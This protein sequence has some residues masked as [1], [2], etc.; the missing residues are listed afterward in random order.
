[1]AGSSRPID[2]RGR[3][4]F[5]ASGAA[6]IR[7]RRDK[8]PTTAASRLSTNVK[9]LGRVRELQERGA[10][11]AEVTVESLINEADAIMKLA[12]ERSQLSAA[13]SALREK[14]ILSGKRV[15][16][17]ERGPPGEFADLENMSTE[18]LKQF[19]LVNLEALGVRPQDL[20]AGPGTA[21]PGDKLN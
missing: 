20:L 21:S 15:E 10:V 18:Q 8:S 3:G 9:I 19:V 1:M 6:P 17:S 16:R 13:V 11:R 2:L 5:A 14:G 4:S 7:L 12:I